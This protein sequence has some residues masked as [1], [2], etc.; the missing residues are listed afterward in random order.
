[1]HLVG[2]G[3]KDLLTDPLHKIS[4][5][6]STQL[7]IALEK[8]LVHVPVQHIL[9]QVE[10]CGLPFNVSELALIPR[11]ETE[12]LTLKIIDSI[13]EHGKPAVLD[14]GTGTGCIPISFKK[15]RP[16][17]KIT[18]VDKSPEALSLAKK[19]AE[20]N[21][22]EINFLEKDFLNETKWNSLGIFDIIISNPPYIPLS[23]L[24]KMDKNV[25]DHEP[26]LALFVPD[27]IPLL[28]YEKI[29]KF[30]Q[31]HL[32]VN[33]TVW[34]EIYADLAK[35]TR[36]LFNPQIYD[37]VLMEDIFGKNRFL[38]ITRYR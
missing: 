18:S 6:A 33:G 38:K 30:A 31:T 15:H 1:M 2:K 17:S 22:T 3:K 28:F 36:A 9:G 7:N 10:F 23:D 19:N 13:S 11:P 21:K 34:L 14:I 5:S 16:L 26:H 32:N 8:L 37:S 20:I 27:D 25:A 24:K 12:E 35:E 4:E 29:E